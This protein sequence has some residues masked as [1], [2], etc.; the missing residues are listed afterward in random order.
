MESDQGLRG[1]VIRVLLAD[2]TRIHTQL[3]ADALK[4]DPGLEVISAGPNSRALLEAANQHHT[5]VLLINSTLEEEPNRGLTVL[6]ELRASRPD[7]R[8]VILLDS[9]KD[10]VVLSAFR[11]GA[12]GIFRRHES[13]ETLRECVRRVHEGQIWANHEELALA[14]RA[15]ASSP[16]VNAM[17]ASGRALLS[18]RE[19]EVVQS[20]SEGLTNQ[21]IAERLGLSQHTVKNYLFRVFDKLG[22]SNRIELLF[23]TMGDNALSSTSGTRP[24][25][26]ACA[27]DRVTLAECEK[28]AVEGVVTAQLALAQR[29]AGK[30]P[31][32][33]YA[34]YLIVEQQISSAGKLM[35]RDMD[36]EQILEAERRAAEWLNKPKKR[37]PSPFDSNSGG[38]FVATAAD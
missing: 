8:A 5:D 1:K 29:I 17:S 11:A 28:A 14:L 26:G 2:N 25:N 3:L 23:M 4:R 13:I 22:V 37:P 18:R 21:E 10:E 36:P 38:R 7:L 20:L 30:N 6:R 12:R 27:W 31:V 33:A 15:L 16:T 35:L 9:S 24:D 34:W 19:L 32:A